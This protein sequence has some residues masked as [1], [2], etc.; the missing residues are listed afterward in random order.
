[1]MK[2]KDNPSHLSRI[3][4]TSAVNSKKQHHSDQLL[5]SVLKSK[6]ARQVKPHETKEL[7]HGDKLQ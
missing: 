6:T 1:M 5:D 3:A 4:S 7:F 2:N